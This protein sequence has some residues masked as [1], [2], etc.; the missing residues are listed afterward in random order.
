MGGGRFKFQETDGKAGFPRITRMTGSKS[1]V[2]DK[3]GLHMPGAETGQPA[4]IWGSPTAPELQRTGSGG[5]PSNARQEEI[6]ATNTISVAT[7]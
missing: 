3:S 7:P 4:G 5:F 6:N 1:A 2:S